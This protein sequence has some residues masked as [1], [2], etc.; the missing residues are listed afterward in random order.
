MIGREP[1][2][3]TA[4]FRPAATVVHRYFEVS[5]FLLLTVGFLTLAS[6]AR[7][8]IFSLL[9]AGTALVFKALRYRRH[10]EPELSPHA[11]TRLTWFYFGFYLIDYLFLSR[12]FLAAT[13]HLILFLA[14]VK[15]F[16]A[17][18]NRDY[19]WL[20]L[21]AFLE[22]LAAAILT[23]DTTFLAFFFVFLL[24]SIS[25]FVSFEIKRGAET[26]RAA[27]LVAG[28][29]LARRLHRS[30]FL[31]SA[32][33]SAG[34]LL[35]ATLIF[36]ILPRF[37][38]GFFSAYAFTPELISG[39]SNNVTLGDIGKIKRNRAVIMRVR[40][41][42]S[43]PQA[44]EGIKWRGI[45]LTQF[46]GKR[47][48][49]E[50]EPTLLLR[51]TGRSRFDLPPRAYPR[52]PSPR[53]LHYRV[54]LEP[55]STDALFVAAVPV[56]LQGRFR[57]L[58]LDTTDSLV[59]PQHRYTKISYAATSA[60][61]WPS[62]ELLRSIPP[63]YP[64]NLRERYLQL[65]PLDPRVP[66][67]AESVADRF[68]SIYDKAAALE[69]YLRTQFGYTL[70]LP[71]V[72]P[73]DP[74]ASFLFDTRRGHCEYFAASMTVMA[75]SLGIPA[76]LVNGFLTGDYNDVGENY[77]VRASDAHTWV[78]IFFP[79][80]GWVEFDPTPPSSD[81]RARTFWT[82]LGNYFDAFD[83][84]WSEWVINYDFSH[85][86]QLARNLERR[87][88]WWS[89]KAHLYFRQLRRNITRSLEQT[90]TRILTSPSLLP[91]LLIL[92]LL[93]AGLFRGRLLGEWLHVAWMLRRRGPAS[94]SG[95]EATLLYQ[96]A[97]KSLARKGFRKAPAQTPREFATAL[98]TQPLGPPVEEF[99][100]LYNEARFGQRPAATPRLLDLLQCIEAWKPGR[101]R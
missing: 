11:V 73:D 82:R 87:T 94:L 30:L 41:E 13:V 26:A 78:E 98:A 15:L 54:L 59:N 35:L 37:T 86:L 3:M 63:D 36:F 23:V 95:R 69:A 39:F 42:G 62:A 6:T 25:T 32:L 20:S 50:M 97:L 67:L 68:E 81:Y 38:T 31:T 48:Y 8:D 12:A 57:L 46:D 60:V 24:L 34:I 96:R 7:L 55:V 91:A 58:G 43:D 28:T 101:T 88:R 49:K 47:W 75:R 64:P 52:R 99:T 33:V 89:L 66:Q 77:I 14:V 4:T 19:L 21:I 61:G 53:T 71:P 16:S 92:L 80:V 40:V 27:P 56:W 83:L 45:A 100:G 76:R 79:G 65:P 29:P 17:R 70:D 74:V 51:P 90:E 10:H 72:L 1:V 5:L 84:W 44:A 93:L 9:F 85:Q 22:I 2:P 18:T